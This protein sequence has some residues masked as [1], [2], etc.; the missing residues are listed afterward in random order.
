LLT[1]LLREPL[2]HFLGLG[3]LVF[4]I[5]YFWTG[6]LEEDERTIVVSESVQ[7]R[8]D[9]TW[10][11]TT[12]SPPSDEDRKGL[13]AQYVQDEALAREAQ[14]LDLGEG[15]EIIKRRL[16][17]KMRFVAT[18]GEGDSDPSGSELQSW[19]EENRD[20]FNIAERRSFN[21]VYF[22][23]EQHGDLLESVANSAL[24]KLKSGANWKSLGDPFMQKRSYVTLPQAEVTRAFGP[25]FAEAIFALPK[26]QWSEPVGSAFGLH[27]VRIETIDRAAKADFAANRGRIRAAYIDAKSQASAQKEIDR[28]VNRY[29]IVMAERDKPTP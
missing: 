17:Q 3:L 25:D 11:R 29:E 22:S 21:H 19:F 24:A 26:G 7:S 12:G 28:I 10:I 16:A 27:L 20:Q 8:L 13:I 6:G 5:N 23:P 14:R 15:D 18:G 2:I 4:L 1:K 9:D